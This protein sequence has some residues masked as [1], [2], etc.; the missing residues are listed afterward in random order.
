MEQIK[1]KEFKKI[2]FRK[3]PLMSDDELENVVGGMENRDPNDPSQYDRDYDR[4]YDWYKRTID[5][6]WYKQCPN[7]GCYWGKC[8]DKYTS[9]QWWYCYWYNRYYCLAC[10]KWTAQLY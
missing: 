1:K 9:D 2:D 8:F 6:A 4:M 10:K 7:C 5:W 3:I